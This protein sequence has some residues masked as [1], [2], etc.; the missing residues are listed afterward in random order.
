MNELSLPISLL[1][2]HVF[3]PRIPYFSEV[4]GFVPEKPFWVALGTSHHD[5]EKHL[6]RNRTLTRFLLE[7]ARRH[8]DHPLLAPGLALHGVVDLLLETDSEVVPVEFKSRHAPRFRG[9]ILQLIAYGLAA[10]ECFQKSFTR[11][12]MVWGNRGRTVVYSATEE[13]TAMAIRTRDAILKDIE[14]A[15]I[16]ETSA[17]PG[18]C[19][20]CEYLNACNDRL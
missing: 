4:L 8:F 16:P 11:G 7:D 2:Q 15:T 6:A 1:R 9:Q 14:T 3:C 18:K 17:S 10:A 13:W 5:R 19:C 12:L 20:Q